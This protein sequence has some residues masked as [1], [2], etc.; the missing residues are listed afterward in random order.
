MA[1]DSELAVAIGNNLDA[2][3]LLSWPDAH[4]LTL[5]REIRPGLVGIGEGL[6]RFF[7]G[8]RLVAGAGGQHR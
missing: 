1:L 4:I 6:D 5:N 2:E 7:L 3:F 8:F